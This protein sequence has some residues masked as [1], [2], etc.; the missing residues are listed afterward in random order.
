MAC[1]GRAG[2]QGTHRL[3]FVV[4]QLARMDQHQD[5]GLFFPDILQRKDMAHIELILHLPV[6]HQPNVDAVG[7]AGLPVDFH[8]R[9]SAAG[10]VERHDADAA[11]G[12]VT[13][14][15]LNRGADRQV[16]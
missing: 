12:A 7:Q 5:V 6:V 4:V 15:D 1:R 3:A 14:S 9:H 2:P 11:V 10:H 13:Q 16:R 8:L